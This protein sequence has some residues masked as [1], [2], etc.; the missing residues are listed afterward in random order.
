VRLE[1]THFPIFGKMNTAIKHFILLAA[2]TFGLNAAAQD[3]RTLIKEGVE[4][5]NARNYTAAIEKYKA[6][7]LL[8]P[9]NA[10]ANYQLAFSLNATGKGIDALPYLQKAVT[11]DATPAIQ[12]AAYALMGSIYDKAAQPQK[13]IDS[14]TLALKT[15]TAN[16]TLHY[17][18]GLAYFRTRQYAQAE[19]S[20]LAA[21]SIEPKH[22]GSTRLYALVTF[23]QNKRAPAL[24]ALCRFLALEPKGP[25]S[26]EA[27]G[28]LQSI[29]KGGA[30]KAE[31]GVKAPV[32]DAQTR[33]LNEVISTAVAT[34]DKRKYTPT[35][36]LLTKQLSAV[37]LQ[38][39]PLV[40]KQD[41]DVYFKGLA[42]EYYQLAVDGGVF[43]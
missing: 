32:I 10:S 29:L 20:A 19:Q 26:A 39:G 34:V 17:N 21:L 1:A 9:A 41:G 18:I 25:K 38:L 28:N 11:G 8:E 16:A 7:L 40:T 33:R 3:A 30:L 35:S 37:F 36:A 5:N 2:L 4:L 31:P 12:S 14:Y 27:Y 24:M 42:A 13:A 6:A 23:H 15:D 43:F 22:P